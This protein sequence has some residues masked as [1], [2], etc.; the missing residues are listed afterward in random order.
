MDILEELDCDLFPGQNWYGRVL[1]LV[2]LAA[3][4][5]SIETLMSMVTIG[6]L[7]AKDNHEEAKALRLIPFLAMSNFD[8]NPESDCD[9]P[10]DE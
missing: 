6:Y 4:S 5:T 1:T 8:T 10:D 9:M 7:H 2:G 3:K